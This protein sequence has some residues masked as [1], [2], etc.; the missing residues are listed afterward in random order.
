MGEMDLLKRLVTG[1]S[2]IL[3]PVV[4]PLAAQYSRQAQVVLNSPLKIAVM[5]PS[6]GPRAGEPISFA[7][8]LQ[9][10]RNQPSAKPN[11][12][13]VEIQLLD[14][15]GAISG[16]GTCTVPANMPEMKCSIRAPKAGL[17][18]IKATPGNKELLEGTGYVLVRPA[19]DLKR[20]VP[21]PSVQKRP[22]AWQ[23]AWSEPGRVRLVNIAYEPPQAG[24]P[25]PSAAS[26]R[27]G[28]SQSRARVILTIN[29][30]GEINGAFRAGVDVATI[31]AFFES[32]DG[33]TAPISRSG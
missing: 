10:G 1:I 16:K 17:Y 33:G 25:A 31:Q 9:N 30:G 26:G 14:S 19:A 2:L 6:T 27:C 18:K 28:A 29:E 32:E 21:A 22:A 23:P 5:P 8:Q 12:T 20:S 3:I 11:E 4:V 15:S 24:E 13:R 7:V